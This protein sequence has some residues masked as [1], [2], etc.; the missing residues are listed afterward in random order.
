M[1][2]E[3]SMISPHLAEENLSKNFHDIS[4]IWIEGRNQRR[5]YHKY[6]AINR[7]RVPTWHDMPEMWPQGNLSIIFPDTIYNFHDYKKLWWDIMNK[8]GKNETHYTKVK[9]G[10][11]W[12]MQG[13]QQPEWLQDWWKD[14][15][16]NETAMDPIF[17]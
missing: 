11:T 2:Y 6:S 15:G 16:L 1:V 14:F 9:F 8:D 13:N 12:D 17:Y 5:V 4:V 10:A 7:T 3:R